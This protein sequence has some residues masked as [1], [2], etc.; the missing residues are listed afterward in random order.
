M[1]KE[2]T[3]T[4][5]PDVA[6]FA[7][8]IV[9][10]DQHFS[11]LKQFLSPDRTVA[12]VT[13]EKIAIPADWK[14]V[15]TDMLYQMECK[16]KVIMDINGSIPID[17]LNE[18]HISQMIELT[19]LT[20]PGPFLQRTIEFGRYHGILE[21][22][23]LVSMAGLRFGAEGYREISAVCTH[24]DY[25]GRGYGGQLMKHMMNEIIYMNQFPFLHVRQSNT[26][27]INLYARLGFIIRQEMYL[28]VIRP[29]II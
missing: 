16:N 26:G 24:P 2:G 1:I 22:D 14:I 21:D 6:P 25:T 20:K 7:G 18:T 11:R 10:D 19:K 13:A 4:F 17:P 8:L 28:N 5:L 15:A 23:R 9:Y 27:A 29:M 3:G 12:L